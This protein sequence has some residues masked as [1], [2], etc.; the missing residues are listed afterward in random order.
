MLDSE[1]ALI[2]LIKYLKIY[3]CPDNNLCKE[4]VK[5]KLIKLYILHEIMKA[6]EKKREINFRNVRR[7]WVRPMFTTITTRG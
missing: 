1:V 3:K 7:F 6:E 2:N 5:Q 4:E